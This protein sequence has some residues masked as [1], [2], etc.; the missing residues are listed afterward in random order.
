M[1]LPTRQNPQT[2]TTEILVNNQ[3]VDFRAYREQQINEAYDSSIRFL[4][5]RLGEDDAR[6][7]ENST[8]E[9]LASNAEPAPGNKAVR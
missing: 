3:W 9:I 7:V 4:R 2:G 6:K 5:D 1:G 8:S